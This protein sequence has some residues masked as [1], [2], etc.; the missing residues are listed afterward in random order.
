VWPIGGALLEPR[1]PWARWNG[2]GDR[3]TLGV[4]EE[5]MLLDVADHSLAECSDEVLARLTGRLAGHTAPE[6]HAAVL[7]LVSDIHLDVAAA[8][9]ELTALRAQLAAELRPMGLDAASAG[10]YPLSGVGETRISHRPRYREVAD[11]MRALAH[12][13]P[14]LAMHAHV[15]LPD[16]ED[17]LR[18]LNGLRGAVPLLLALSANSPYSQGRDTGFASTRTTIFQAFPRTGTPRRFDSYDDYVGAVDG[19]VASSAIPDP[20]FLWWDV[21]LQ[22]RL[23]T[24]E[25]R[26]MD[27]Q[28]AIEDTAALVALV[29]SLARMILDDDEET[30]HEAGSEVLAENRFLAARDGLGAR[31]IDPAGRRLVPVRALLEALIERC[32]PHASALGCLTEFEG[33]ELLTA[34]NGADRQRAVADLEGLRGLASVLSAQF[35]EERKN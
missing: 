25:V 5:V 10:T 1:P 26:V 8:V 20:S 33:I 32:R 3:Y 9:A 7:E 24:V 13:E 11:T 14:T 12:R 31:L 34:A 18:V 17:A 27:A 6:T 30:G 23:G 28:S 29:Q 19:L 4:E 16:P 2:A 15:G 35:S 22:P 21:R